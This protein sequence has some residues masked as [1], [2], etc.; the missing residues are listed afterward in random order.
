MFEVTVDKHK[1]LLLTSVVWVHSLKYWD[2][3]DIDSNKHTIA[4]SAIE[5]ASIRVKYDTLSTNNSVFPVRNDQLIINSKQHAHT[6]RQSVIFWYLSLV[7]C[8]AIVNNE[9]FTHNVWSLS[10]RAV[11]HLI[12]SVIN[13]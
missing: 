13:I 3:K 12:T 2:L 11:W 7:F 1:T 8:I 4:N 10:F 9:A 5:N 6:M